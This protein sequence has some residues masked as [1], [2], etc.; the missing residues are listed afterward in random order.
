MLPVNTISFY[1]TNSVNLVDINNYKKHLKLMQVI[2]KTESYHAFGFISNVLNLQNENTLEQL[3]QTDEKMNENMLI[4]FNKTNFNFD[5]SHFRYISVLSINHHRNEYFMSLAHVARF[6]IE[7]C[8]KNGKNTSG[9]NI[10]DMYNGFAEKL[11][12]ADELRNP[13]ADMADI[14]MSVLTLEM[15]RSIR[16][17]TPMIE[18]EIADQ[19]KI[20]KLGQIKEV[21]LDQLMQKFVEK[22]FVEKV[23]NQAS[24]KFKPY[25]S[26]YLPKDEA[27]SLIKEMAQLKLDKKIDDAMLLKCVGQYGLNALVVVVALIGV[28]YSD[29]KDILIKYFLK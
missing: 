21:S 25:V 13:N 5:K 23:I 1:V 24:I 9:Q 12:D 7:T 14:I 28:Y 2:G 18:Q 19:L 15:K 6:I 27:M 16:D 17:L 22:G 8:L 26:E 10:V 29:A 3:M 4:D 20:Y 11:K